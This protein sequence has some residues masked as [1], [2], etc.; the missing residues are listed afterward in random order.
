MQGRDRFPAARLPRRLADGML[1]G[2][3]ET[4][5]PISR[6]VRPR[7][8]RRLSPP[9]PIRRRI[10]LAVKRISWAYFFVLLALWGFLRVMGDRWWLATLMLFGP[11]WVVILPAALLIPAAIGFHPRSLVVLLG[12]LGVA[13]FPLMGCCL[14]WRTLFQGHF[15]GQ[16]LRLL[17][18]N[19]HGRFLNES[20]LADL[21]SDT[22]PDVI[23]LQEF[24]AQFAPAFLLDGH[25]YA[26][27]DGELFIAS[28]YPIPT[29]ENFG[30]ANW[31]EWG[32]AAMRYDIAAP[33]GTIHLFNLHLA[34]PHTPFQAVIEGKESGRTRVANHLAVRAEQ[35]QKL[36]RIMAGLGG[37]ALA[38]G[39]FNT[40]CAGSIYHAYW[41]RFSDAFTASGV[42]FGHTYFSEGATVRIDHILTA[43]DWQSRHCWVGPD[44]GSPHRPVIADLERVEV[45]K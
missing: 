45:G 20:A 28:R 11:M 17:T 40:P 9:R 1:A 27:E 18:C 41:A 21:I 7:G 8:A 23:V 32:G 29:S 12:G 5:E 13:F 10:A 44:L 35:S 19:V 22:K 42:G 38:A 31:F 24:P 15:E 34:S 25:W 3:M 43:S 2:C 26:R 33:Q 14:P 36:S 39:D 4:E 6:H 30:E 16:H 37:A